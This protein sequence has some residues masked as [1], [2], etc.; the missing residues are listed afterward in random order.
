MSFESFFVLVAFTVTFGALIF[1]FDD[2]FIDVYALWKGLKPRRVSSDFIGTLKSIPEKNVAILIANWKEADV[3]E[4]MIRGNLRGLDYKNYTFFLGVYPNDLPTWEAARKLEDLYPHKVSVIVNTQYGPTSKGQMLNE[5]VRQILK[6]EILLGKKMDAFLLQDSEDVLHPHS[7][8]LMNHESLQA[9]FVQIPVFSFNVPARS[10]V[11]GVY[12]DE[13]A[14][15]HTKDLLV[16]ESLG[17]A[18]PS[19]GVGTFISKKLVQELVRTQEGH[20]LNENTL[21]E[22]YHLGLMAKKLGFKSTFACVRYQ[23]D[24]GQTEFIATR[25]YFPSSLGASMRQKSR[26]TLGIA[27]QGLKNFSWDGSLVDQYFMWRDR[28]GPWNSALIVLS[29]AL[30][31]CFVILR[32]YDQVPSALQNSFFQV[33]AAVNMFN[34][35]VRVLQ[36]MRAV[37]LTNG[38]AQAWLVPV[39]WLVANVVNVGATWKASRQ[40]RD[41][42]RT[43]QRPVWIKTDHRMPEHFGK[44]VEVSAP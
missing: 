16:R 3:L 5:M 31:L 25:E 39:R 18:I 23:K 34:L 37:R 1:T 9:D 4:A 30:L 42:Q 36:R 33:L 19:A 8:S 24:N 11:A 14:E 17:A 10:L 12:I 27:F 13:F 44:E 26:W 32:G 20:F 28:R 6:S 15:S 29:T 41:S 35:F 40:Y 43:G 22:D 38:K 2:L 7:L 21:T